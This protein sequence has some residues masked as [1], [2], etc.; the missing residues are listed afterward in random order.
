V[1]ELEVE[2]AAAQ[3]RAEQ[4][5]A[6]AKGP[7]AE[8]AKLQKELERLGKEKSALES[9]AASERQ[10]LEG[11][12]AKLEAEASAAKASALRVEP[13]RSSAKTIAPEKITPDERRRFEGKLAELEK[14]RDSAAAALEE[15]RRESRELRERV[16]QLSQTKAVQADGEGNE[17]SELRRLLAQRDE[18]LQKLR[19]RTFFGH[20]LEA[21]TE[22]ASAEPPE[23]AR[24]LS[25]KREIVL[26]ATL[27]GGVVAGLLFGEILFHSK[28]DG[29]A[30]ASKPALPVSQAPAST[31]P[32][33]P[34]VSAGA[35]AGKP[36]AKSP[37]GPMPASAEPAATVGATPAPAPPAFSAGMPAKLPDSFL[38]IKFGSPLSD[39]PGRAQWQETQGNR[40][41]KAELLNASVEAVLSQDDQGRFIMG[42]YVRVVPRQTE[43]ITPF[44]EWA[45]NAQDAVSALYGEPS[46]IHQIQGASDAAEVVRKIVSAEDYYQATWERD[47]ED[48]M[49]DLS[50]RVFNERT[51]VFRLEY[52]SRELTTA[53]AL[54][55][56]QSSATQPP[57]LEEK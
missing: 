42:S 53:F 29:A 52:R 49:M 14:G 36:P 24:F 57:G 19:A 3:K 8:A 38:G 26:G 20:G 47:G 48:T 13:D 37:D 12:V 28:E 9:V 23:P 54:K 5:E 10:R 45:V 7:A 21:L 2:R 41:R 40:H 32:A 33:A 55:Q 43:A 11:R 34:P 1:A 50:I 31:T 16:E 15:A 17:R 30:D 25:R 56:S 22:G 44:L 6:N 51:V 46:Q 18:E 35:S 27:V 4:A 39:L